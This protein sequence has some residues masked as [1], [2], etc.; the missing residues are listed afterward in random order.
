MFVSLVER[1]TGAADASLL[2][3]KHLP[4]DFDCLKASVNAFENK[5]GRMSDYALK[6]VKVL[7][8]LCEEK[9]SAERVASEFLSIDCN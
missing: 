1:V 7:A 4:R 3:F 2:K 6:Y 5:C 9:F 8:N